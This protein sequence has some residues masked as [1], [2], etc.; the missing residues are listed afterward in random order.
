MVRG[1]PTPDHGHERGGRG[2][3]TAL[4]RCGTIGGIVSDYCHV[5]VPT[6]SLCVLGA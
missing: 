3:E 4:Q 6:S 2:V 1:Q 5:V